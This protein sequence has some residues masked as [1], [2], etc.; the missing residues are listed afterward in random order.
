MAFQS[1]TIE[2][3]FSEVEA[4]FP[5]WEKLK[6]MVDQ[7]IDMMLNLRQSGHPGGSRSKVHMLLA[8]MLSG[9][10]RYDIRHPEKRFSDRFILVAGHTIP[11]VYATLAVLNEAL[12]RKFQQT[13]DRKYQIAGEPKMAL[14]W[15]DLLTL[16]HNGGLPG[17][18][19][20]AGKTLFLKFNTGPSGH[21]SPVA[22]GQAAA[23]KLTGADDI[24]VFAIEG[25]GGLTAGA[26]HETKNSAWGLGLNNLYF[27]VDWNDF[28]IDDHRISAIVH[29]SPRDWF[30]AH[31]WRVFGTEKGMQWET[32]SRTLIEMVYGENSAKQPNISW[33]KTRKGRDYGLY[34]NKSHGTPHKPMNAPAFWETTK[35]FTERYG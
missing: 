22:A 7:C 29:G 3:K 2:Q 13:G 35:I 14:Y 11:L 15:E 26:I 9:I 33:F 10:M 21:G 5:S 31:G 1:Q 27:L 12:R 24:R 23:L 20:M 32:L 18:A 17:H 4:H 19:E 25:E 16:R 30:A 28:G 34:D 8:T 6:D